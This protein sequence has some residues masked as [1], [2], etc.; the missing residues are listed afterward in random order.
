MVERFRKY[1]YNEII[2][3]LLS[4]V[5]IC[6]LIK[7]CFMNNTKQKTFNQQIVLIRAIAILIVI[8]GHSIILYDPSWGIYKT[9]VQAPYFLLLK[10][11]INV[12]QMPLF[13][14]V[15]GFLFFYGVNKRNFWQ[16]A[17][18]K[19][20]RLIIPYI[21]IALL[22]MNPIKLIL[23]VPGY[24]YHGIPN[25]LLNQILLQ[26]NGHLW[27]LP[28]LF[29]IFLFIY[30]LVKYVRNDIV[31]S[32]MLICLSYFSYKVPQI[33]ELNFIAQYSVFFYVGYLS[34]KYTLKEMSNLIYVAAFVVSLISA[35]LIHQPLLRI[36]A[37]LV[38]LFSLYNINFGIKPNTLITTISKESYGM[39][40]FHSPLIYITYTFYKDVNPFLV[41]SVNFIVMGFLAYLLSQQIGKSKLKWMIGG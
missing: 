32:L 8:L 10:K 40:L 41:F 34:N 4:S 25:L 13:F 20:K 29:F 30:L 27:F 26:N 28:C 38:S 6:N 11:V 31:I 14:S 33:V 37:L 12:I 24:D 9:A 35:L 5:C 21:C 36:L 17:K 39:Y 19:C 3:F 16:L 18:N 23:R 1:K 15:S 22:W 2:I 7:S